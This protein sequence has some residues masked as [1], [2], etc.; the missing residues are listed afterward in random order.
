MLQV[1]FKQVSIILQTYFKQAS[2]NLQATNICILFK[3][4]KVF[5]LKINCILTQL[6]SSCNLVMPNIWNGMTGIN[7]PW[8]SRGHN[9]NI[10]NKRIALNYCIF[11]MYHRIFMYRCLMNILLQKKASNCLRF[12]FWISKIKFLII[13]RFWT[14]LNLI[15]MHWP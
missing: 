1:G 15:Q 7:E 11:A 12:N 4:W 6:S 2:C 10:H 14:F 13:L 9:Q 8:N 5:C 3:G